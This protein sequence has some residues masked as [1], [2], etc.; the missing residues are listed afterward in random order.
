MSR[1]LN[2]T[3]ATYAL[4]GQINPNRRAGVGLIKEK[5]NGQ[6]TRR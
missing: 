3:T 2:R 6:E 1:H 5:A 4:F